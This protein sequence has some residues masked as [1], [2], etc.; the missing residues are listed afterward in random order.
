M[1]IKPLVCFA[2][3]NVLNLSLWY[4][5]TSVHIQGCGHR[6]KDDSGISKVLRDACPLA[7]CVHVCVCVT[8]WNSLPAVHSFVGVPPPV[9]VCLSVQLSASQLVHLHLSAETARGLPQRVVAALMFGVRRCGWGGELRS[10]GAEDFE[11]VGWSPRTARC[12]PPDTQTPSEWID[13]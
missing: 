10:A 7:K 4:R 3:Q 13:S 11:P 5:G 12:I 2:N 8:C 6:L 9:L 1:I